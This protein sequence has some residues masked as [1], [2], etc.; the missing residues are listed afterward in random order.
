MVLTTEKMRLDKWLWSAR[1]YKTRVLAADAINGGHVRVN[2]SRVKASRQVAVGDVVE[3]RKA[4]V[5]F[6]LTITALSDKRGP[7]SVAQTLYSEHD[8][9][10][11]AREVAA[12][13]RREFRLQNPAPQKRPDKR[14]RRHIIRFVRKSSE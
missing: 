13:Q 9:S 14:A 10:R 12:E 2:R 1:F 7:A 6:T 11:L 8:E 3:V 5:S 4:P